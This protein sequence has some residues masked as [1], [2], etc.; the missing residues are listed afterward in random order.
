[1][2]YGRARDGAIGH[3]AVSSCARRVCQDTTFCSSTQFRWKYDDL[4]RYFFSIRL[5]G[6]RNADIR[7]GRDMTQLRRFLLIGCEGL[8]DVNVNHVG[9]RGHVEGTARKSLDFSDN[10]GDW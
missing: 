3:S 9:G 2:R 1:M 7:R 6:R 8:L 5:L 10:A 4:L